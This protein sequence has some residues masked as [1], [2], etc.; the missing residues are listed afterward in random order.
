[1]VFRVVA[2]PPSTLAPPRIGFDL[3]H[4]LVYLDR[5]VALRG[6]EEKRPYELT[7]LLALAAGPLDLLRAR[8]ALHGAPVLRKV[9]EWARVLAER[10]LAVWS[11]RDA[12]SLPPGAVVSHAPTELARA[13]ERLRLEL[14]V[15]GRLRA[16]RTGADA[17]RARL[18]AIEGMLLRQDHAGVL[19]AVHGHADDESFLTALARGI[20]PG[21]RPRLLVVAHTLAGMA[22]MNTADLGAAE[23][24]LGQAAAIAA[25]LDRAAY[26]RARVAVTRSAVARMRAAFDPARAVEHLRAGLG[27]WREM[28]TMLDADELPEDVR[29]ALVAWR[30]EM[31]TPVTLLADLGVSDPLGLREVRGTIDH[32]RELGESPFADPSVGPTADLME[33]RVTLTARQERA[34]LGALDSFER[35]VAAPGTPAWIRGW[36]PRYAADLAFHGGCSPEGL[37]GPIEHAWRTNAALRFQQLL[38]L[39]RVAAWGLPTGF[40]PPDPRAETVDAMLRL[41][42]DVHVERHGVAIERCFRCK[43]TGDVRAALGRRITCALGLTPTGPLALGVWR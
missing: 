32:A 42:A 23:S 9:R 41:A 40:R 21:A 3:G 8:L 35:K 28:E 4:A 19:R 34:A 15:D 11:G 38:V 43:T 7:L 5:R 20:T 16:T 39:A 17:L 26:W 31:A 36:V 24:H 12:L 37:W 14:A 2:A 18:A 30:A 10:G 6:A 1:M 25:S 33:L 13:G 27:H 22:A 29:R